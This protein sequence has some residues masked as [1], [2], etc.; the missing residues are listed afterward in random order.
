MND[1]LNSGENPLIALHLEALMIPISEEEAVQ[2]VQATGKIKDVPEKT[3][4]FPVP[5][6]APPCNFMLPKLGKPAALYAYHMASGELLGYNARFET[7]NSDTGKREKTIL[8]VCFCN[9]KGGKRAWR[10]VGMPVPRPL[11][12]LPELS[13]RGEATVLICEGEK[14]ADAAQFLFPD[15][16]ATTPMH[17]AKS[18]HKTD[19]TSLRGRTVMISPD[20]DAAGEAFAD[21]VYDLCHDAGATRILRLSPETFGKWIFTEEGKIPRGETIPEGYDL[22]DALADGWTAEAIADLPHTLFEKPYIA[23]SKMEELQQGIPESTF[24]L[25]PNGVELRKEDKEGNVEWQWFCSFLAVTCQTRDAAGENWGRIVELVDNDGRRKEYVLPM[26]ALAGDG[27][28]YRETLFSLGLRLSPH[29]KNH[30]YSYITVCNPLKRATCVPKTGWHDV[31]GAGQCFVLPGKVYG[32]MARERIVLQ[33]E[34]VS[35]HYTIKGTVLEWQQQIGR[36]CVSNT[37][38]LLAISTAL[39]GPLLELLGEENFGLHLSGGSS[40]GKTTALIVA[41]SIWGVPLA[42]WRTTDNA[43]ESLACAANDTALFLDELSQ[44]GGAAADAMAYMLGNGAGKARA[45]KDGSARTPLQFRLVFL[46]T[47]EIGLATKMLECGK[48]SKAGQAVRFIEIAADAGKGHG[49]F[50]CIH[51]AKDGNQ[52]SLLLKDRA[53]RYQGSVG[54]AF[55]QGLVS[56]REEVRERISSARRNWVEKYVTEGCDGQVQRVAQK[57]A[58]IAAAGELAIHLGIFPLQ[59]ETVSDACVQLLGEWVAGRGGTQ[60]HEVDQAARRLRSLVAKHGSSRFETPWTEGYAESNSIQIQKVIDRLGFKRLTAAKEW[61][62]FLLP[63]A[64]EQEVIGGMAPKLAKEY[65][66]DQGLIRR[67][68]QRK[69]TVSLRVPGFKQMRLYHIPAGILEAG[70]DDGD[71]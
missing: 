29:A 15:M 34:Q 67:D 42:S 51:D 22:A 58:L 49:L 24:R 11:Y 7:V 53:K 26:T 45:R 63:D 4:I 36:Y 21:M 65:L 64:F 68:E 19:W 6:D 27:V 18:P 12:R 1:M 55:L 9:V 71:A 60:A 37:R 50:E 59:P 10:S 13:K 41:A 57:F 8:P 39:C 43:A 3:P 35:T 52:L 38:L 54:D 25:R 56:Q 69:Y 20:V 14:T 30:L 48:Q 47:G 44:V 70:G 46:S 66:A 62:Y 33:Q 40:I 17:G 28:A 5:D 31:S 23:A 61:E 32:M 16:V 2:A